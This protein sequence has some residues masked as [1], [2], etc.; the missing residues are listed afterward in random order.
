L[1]PVYSNYRR[2]I[3]P[4][5]GVL[6]MTDV[7]GQRTRRRPCGLWRGKQRTDDRGRMTEDGGKKLRKSEDQKEEDKKIR[8]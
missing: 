6:R 8:S 2:Q 5:Y 4:I 3:N 7:G 1:H